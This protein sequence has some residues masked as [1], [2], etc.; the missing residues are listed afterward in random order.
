MDFKAFYVVAAGVEMVLELIFVE[1]Q[2]GPEARTDT[3]ASAV[4]LEVGK[5]AADFI[6][7]FL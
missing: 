7:Q 1:S 3:A 2:G 4:K 6:G 5:Q